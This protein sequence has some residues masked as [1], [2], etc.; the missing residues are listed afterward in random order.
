MMI[1]KIILLLA[2]VPML[3]ELEAVELFLTPM[4]LA[5]ALP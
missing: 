5:Q 3:T 1:Y 4:L 2:L